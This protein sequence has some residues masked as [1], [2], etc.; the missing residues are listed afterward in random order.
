VSEA[1]A[2]VSEAGATAGQARAKAAQR[3]PFSAM[4]AQLRPYRRRLAVAVLVV[5]AALGATLAGPAL[6]AYAIDD[7]LVNHHSMRVVDVAGAAYVVV[8]IAYFVLTRVQTLMVSGIG[9]SFLNDLRRRVFGHLLAQPLGFFE[10]ESSGQL[11]SRMTADIDVLESLV[12]S[13]LSSFVTSIGL[14]VAVMVVLVV[15]SPL[16]CLVVVASLVPV[17]VSAARYRKSSTR[18]YGEVRHLIGGAL[19]TLDESLAGVRVVQAFRQED[20]VVRRFRKV[21]DAQLDGELATVRLS[22]RFFPKVEWSGAMSSVVVLLVGALMVQ[23]HMTSVGTVAAFVLYLANLFNAITS[24]SSLFDLLQSSGAALATVFELL[25]VGSSMVDPEEPVLLPRRGALELEGVQFAYG[26]SPVEDAQSM[27][28][29]LVLEG[30]D[31]RVEAGERLVLVGPTGGG[32]ST[33]A[34]LAGRL[35]DPV[36]GSVRFGGVDLREALLAHIRERIVVLPQEGFLFRGTVLENVALGR[37]G[38]TLAEARAA[39]AQLGLEEW[40]ASL[41]QGEETDVGE[42]GSH[43]SA[44][45]KQLVSLA[46]AAL[47][48]PA[49]LIMDEATSSIDPGTERQAEA[50]LARLAAGRTVIVVAHRL[51]VAQR[52]DRVAVVRDGALAEVGS[53]DELL[54]ADG[55]YARLFA[56]W[57]GASPAD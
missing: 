19:A 24:L 40:V 34:K 10:T 42:R 55:H 56:A 2:T 29:R 23:A 1:R 41:P 27:E 16:L 45:E 6:V 21:N 26:V 50:A 54:E 8:G 28:G 7:G 33:L 3:G 18:A 12:Q 11:L 4:L 20:A 25:A 48:D 17:V 39:I 49:V 30:V 31:L 9:E 22:S 14:M 38:A 32:K 47:T 37:T 51:A 15:M 35:Y 13:G 46:R 44:G 36:A 52:A 53:H 57:S 43:L 5:V